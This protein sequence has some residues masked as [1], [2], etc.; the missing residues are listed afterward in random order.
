MAG[1]GIRARMRAWMTEYAY[2]V[3][4]GA[5]AAI[6][7][8]SAMYAY[9][10]QGKESVQA[11]ADAPETAARQT[12]D[13]WAQK[14]AVT[15]LPAIEPLAVRAEHPGMYGAT[16][17]P[18][19]GGIIRGYDAQ[20]AVYWGALGCYMPHAALDIAGEA[21][22]EVAA[23]A[24]GAVETTGRDELWGCRATVLQTDGRRMHYAGL[25]AVYVTAGQSVTR[26]QPIGVLM[27]RIPCEA[28]LGAHV[29]VEMT[30]DGKRQDP[31][32]MLPEKS[33]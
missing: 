23:I 9:R 24:D 31:G 3:T 18:V 14:P 20:E 16:A 17:W 21:G 7:A 5:L 33:F 27:P 28:E 13:V 22:E 11:A 2:L 29:H 4:A 1:N 25:E 12:A 30:R 15:P 19:S 6:V 10:L 8:A 32:V 26:G